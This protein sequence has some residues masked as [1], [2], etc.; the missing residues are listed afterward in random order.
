[1]KKTPPMKKAPAS[2][3]KKAVAK[4]KSSMKAAAPKKTIA[5]PKAKASMKAAARAKGKAKA[6]AKAKEKK[7]AATRESA[8]SA[9][10]DADPAEEDS[11]REEEVADDKAGKAT[12]SKAA[13]AKAKS[14]RRRAPKKTVRPRKWD[15]VTKKIS[16]ASKEKEVKDAE[17]NPNNPYGRERRGS[18]FDMATGRRGRMRVIRGTAEQTPGYL[19][20]EDFTVNKQGRYVAKVASSIAKKRYVGSAFEKWTN[21]IKQAKIA[22]CITGFVPVGGPT[23]E[24][25]AL[26][27]KA[28]A[29]LD[30]VEDKKPDDFKNSYLCFV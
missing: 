23:P 15:G 8:A 3:M 22:M 24:G 5:K 14:T 27:K 13:K 30:K 19:R 17:I 7:V 11:P 2:S 6:K 1:M 10:E 16:R 21:A 29:I 25:Q 20:K 26:Y 12:G 28:K 4:P 9:A 18:K